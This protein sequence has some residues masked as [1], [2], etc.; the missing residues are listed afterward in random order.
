M[1]EERRY[2]HERREHDR[3]PRP[4]AHEQPDGLRADEEDAEV[5]RRDRE[6]ADHGPPREP[7]TVAAEGEPEGEHRPRSEQR[8]QRVRPGLL[9]VPDEERVGRDQRRGDEARSPGHETAPAPYATGIVAVPASAESERSPT[10]PSP[11][12]DLQAQATT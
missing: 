9:R 12:S 10:S 11:N 5:V 2:G 6:A 1:A 7:A 4:E 3:A 8:E